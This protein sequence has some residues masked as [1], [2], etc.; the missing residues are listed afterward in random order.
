MIQTPLRFFVILSLLNS[1]STAMHSFSSL[2]EMVAYAKKYDEIIEPD[3]HD[4]INPDY[5]SAYALRQPPRWRSI[6]S[7][8]TGGLIPS[9]DFLDSLTQ[10]LET[11]IKEREVR[12]FNNRHVGLLLHKPEDV[13]IVW[14]D[15]QGAFHSCVRALQEL[16]D[17][18]ILAD[19]L[20]VIKKNHYLVFNGDFTGESAETLEL[21]ECIACLMLKN[22]HNVICL[23]GQLED[24]G[25][26]TDE[27]LRRQLTALGHTRGVQF[28][29][30]ANA[31]RV[32]KIEQLLTRFFNCLPIAL[33]IDYPTRTGS[34][35][36]HEL[37]RISGFGEEATE[38]N[39]RLLDNFFETAS[40]ASREGDPFR[41]NDTL[42]TYRLENVIETANPA[43][44]R[45]FVISIPGY[46]RFEKTEGLLELESIDGSIVWS[47][48]SAPVIFQRRTNRFYFDAFAKIVL[49]EKLDDATIELIHRDAR[50]Q[51]PFHVEEKYLL[52]SGDDIIKHRNTLRKNANLVAF[53]ADLD[54]SKGAS[55]IGINIRRGIV[56]ALEDLQEDLPVDMTKVRIAFFDNQFS[57]KKSLSNLRDIQQHYGLPIILFPPTIRSMQNYLPDLKNGS[58]L[59]LFP[60]DGTTTLHS[61]EYPGVL[62]YR[63]SFEKEIQA[64]IH[65][66]TVDSSGGTFCFF[67]Q[68][69]DFGRN[70]L[71]LAYKE[72]EKTGKNKAIA[73]SHLPNDTNFVQQIKEFKKHNFEAVFFFSL[74][75]AVREFINQLDT[76]LLVQPSLYGLSLLSGRELRY[77][78]NELGLFM[79]LTQVVPN[80]ATSNLP[81]AEEYRASMDSRDIPYSSFGFEG[82]ICT[83]ILLDAVAHIQGAVT[84]EKLVTYLSSLNNYN[85]KGLVLTFRPEY[86]DLSQT[87]WLDQGGPEWKV[88]R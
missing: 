57:A 53:G 15:L 50:T 65:S 22:P 9:H 24:H 60:I 46:L 10:T 44:T 45:V 39:T 78:L 68:D 80:A 3:N 47:I 36:Q 79:T 16:K 21:L 28:A 38:L 1:F 59:A 6:A 2:S 40:S 88:Y 18:G 43:N 55:T 66:A 23:S 51:E 81:I 82:Y 32:A 61:K 20:S 73:L 83:S 74:P 84:K 70:V 8:L 72:L 52:L 54:L 13:L 71:E 35:Y 11:L 64:L 85:L 48:F 67:Y 7:Y 69:D 63:P 58:L 62:F 76:M 31:E 33:F 56:A 14:G 42:V 41:G 86:R 34:K 49:T 87:I 27:G 37:I 26:W 30:P 25:M 19:D 4:L 29:F 5:F 12:G 77:F 17:Q 75:L